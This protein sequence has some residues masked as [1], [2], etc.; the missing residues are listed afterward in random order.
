MDI[1]KEKETEII[2]TLM[3]LTYFML[4]SGLQLQRNSI[5]QQTSSLCYFFR[6][7]HL[8]VRKTNQPTKN[9]SEAMACT[10]VLTS[11]SCTDHSNS[12][13]YSSLS[14]GTCCLRYDMSPTKKAETYFYA[15]CSSVVWIILLYWPQKTSY[16]NTVKLY[17]LLCRKILRFQNSWLEARRTPLSSQE[18]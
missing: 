12:M 6:P 14:A 2:P 7:C 18:F 1:F 15:Q 9:F 11:H 5:C 8:Q 16:Y 13:C 10:Q 4:V 17:Y 3:N